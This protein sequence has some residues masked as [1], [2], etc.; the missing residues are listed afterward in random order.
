MGFQ[1]GILKEKHQYIKRKNTTN[2]I[3]EQ[4]RTITG[5]GK[6]KIP[7]LVAE[8]SASCKKLFLNKSIT[9]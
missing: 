2:T 5:C 1:K 6:N 8:G 7:P 3:I 4:E 9:S